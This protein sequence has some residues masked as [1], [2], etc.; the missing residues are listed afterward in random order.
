MP[1]YSKWRAIDT[2][3]LNDQWIAHND[4]ITDEYLQK[5]RPDIIMWHGYFSPLFPPA[6]EHSESSQWS[7]QVI[8]LK[9]Y[10]EKHRFTLAAV[11]GISPKDTHYYYV[12]SE[13]PDHDEIVQRIRS[14]DYAWFGNG[15]ICENYASS[16]P[17]E[18][19]PAPNTIFLN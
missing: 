7:R 5:Q 3:G 19:V 12:R 6:P 17:I 4:L 9:R 11:F 13:I 14:I 15:A 2:W 16:H 10:A 1:L 18:H 8:T